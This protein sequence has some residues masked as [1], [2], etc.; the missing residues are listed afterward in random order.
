MKLQ[1]IYTCKKKFRYRL[2][3]SCTFL[4]KNKVKYSDKKAWKLVDEITEAFQYYLLKPSNTLAKERGVHEYFDKT[5][6]SDSV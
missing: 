5:K 2:Y 6:Y 3:W 1:K 4:A